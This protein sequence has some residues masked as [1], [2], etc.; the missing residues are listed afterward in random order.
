MNCRFFTTKIDLIEKTF[1]D[2]SWVDFYKKT[3]RVT[4]AEKMLIFSFLY[5]QIIFEI[6]LFNSLLFWFFLIK[7]INL[8]EFFRD[9]K[10]ECIAV[11][12]YKDDSN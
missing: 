10:Q 6:F 12:S 1:G 4:V 8:S 5:V 9:A 7:K 11:D 3:T 2:T